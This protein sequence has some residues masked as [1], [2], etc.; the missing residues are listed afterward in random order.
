MITHYDNAL[1]HALSHALSLY[2][3]CVDFIGFSFSWECVAHENYHADYALSWDFS[4][5]SHWILIDNS[6]WILM[7]ILIEFSLNSHWILIEFSR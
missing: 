3:A 1:S 4:L 6:H 7:R 2:H 5:N